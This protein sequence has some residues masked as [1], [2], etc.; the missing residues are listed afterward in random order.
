GERFWARVV[1][2]ALYD[3]D[4]KLGG[5]AKVTQDLSQREYARDLERTAQRLNEFVAMLAHELRNP[6]APIRTAVHMMEQLPAADPVQADMRRTIERQSR[7]LMRI[8]DDMLDIARITRGTLS[9]DQ[10]N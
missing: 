9:I 7:H 8:V 4:G 6:L 10:M 1:V 3:H 5:Y 2:T